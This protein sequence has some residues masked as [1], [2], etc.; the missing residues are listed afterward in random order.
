VRELGLLQSPVEEA[1]LE[2][3]LRWFTEQ[4]YVTK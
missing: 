2:R 3:A 1:L 4:G